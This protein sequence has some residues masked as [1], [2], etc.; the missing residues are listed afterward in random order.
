MDYARS[1][2]DRLQVGSSLA[3]P[4]RVSSAP[5]SLFVITERLVLQTGNPPTTGLIS[6]AYYRSRVGMAPKF[7]MLTCSSTLLAHAATGACDY[8]GKR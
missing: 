8:D 3:N 1:A 4:P 6:A 7:K 5:R 2:D